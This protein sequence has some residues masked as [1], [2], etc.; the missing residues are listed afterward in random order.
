MLQLGLSPNCLVVAGIDLCNRQ[1]VLYTGT[2]PTTAK[3]AS[4]G[5]HLD[6]A[7]IGADLTS[8]YV[9]ELYVTSRQSDLAIDERTRETEQ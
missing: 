4:T 7:Y 5:S 9:G 6:D 3:K 8:F 2:D 1:T